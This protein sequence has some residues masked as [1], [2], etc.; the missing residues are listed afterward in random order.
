MPATSGVEGYSAEKAH[1]RV[2]DLAGGATWRIDMR[3]GALTAPEAAR[4]ERHIDQCLDR[5]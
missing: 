3:L 4:M 5:A 1:G 2:V